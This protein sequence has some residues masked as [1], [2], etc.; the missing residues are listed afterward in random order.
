MMNALHPA[1]MAIYRPW[2][3]LLRRP[4]EPAAS[5]DVMPC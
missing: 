5:L 4:P 3:A 2:P 1:P